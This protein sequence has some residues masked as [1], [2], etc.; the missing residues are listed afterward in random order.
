MLFILT[1]AACEAA[2]RSG[3]DPDAL[4]QRKRRW[5]SAC[6]K[7][8]ASR[9]G[10]RPKT[11]SR[12]R[13]RR[14]SRR[15]PPLTPG[16]PR[17]R[18]PRRRRA[19]SEPSSLPLADPRACRSAASV[20]IPSSARDCCGSSSHWPCMLGAVGRV[21]ASP[22]RRCSQFGTVYSTGTRAAPSTWFQARLRAARRSSTSASTSASMR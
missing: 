14:R 2:H 17:T 18:P 6:G 7:S 4:P 5:T 20:I 21:S 11:R 3:A 15:C 9:A 1:V 10:S 13:R 16:W 8:C 12:C 22:R 19:M